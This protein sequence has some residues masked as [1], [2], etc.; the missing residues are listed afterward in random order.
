[1]R[2]ADELEQIVRASEWFMAAL[3]AARR[4]DPPDWY[5]GAGALRDL[6]WDTRFGAGSRPELVKDVD[7]AFYDAGD[8][9]E[10]RE[11][12][13]ETALRDAAALA[14]DAKNQAA[15]HLWYPAKFGA[16]VEPL[17]SAADGIATWPETATAI[18]VRLHANDALEI[19]APFG[20]NDLL[21]GVWR[22]NPRRVSAAE[23]RRRIERKR[24]DL[25]WPAVRVVE[26]A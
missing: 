3:R 23:Y 9:S 22:R 25:R 20:L 18:G 14:W 12:A 5:V 11:G 6:V 8:L 1:V 21:D 24:P 7:L 17:R 10:A 16:H 19:A 2:R 13:V 26:D 4:V 15:V